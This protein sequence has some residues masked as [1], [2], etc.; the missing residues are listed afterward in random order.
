MPLDSD[1]QEMDLSRGVILTNLT[2]SQRLYDGR[3]Q[4]LASVRMAL[5]ELRHHCAKLLTHDIVKDDLPG[6]VRSNGLDVD[7]PSP[8]RGQSCKPFRRR[9]YVYAVPTSFIEQLCDGIFFRIISP[10]IDVESGLGR[11]FSQRFEEQDILV[12]LSVA[13]N[14]HDPSLK[15]TRPLIP[16]RP[17]M[18][19]LN[20]LSKRRASFKPLK[21]GSIIEREFQLKTLDPTGG[22]RGRRH[23]QEWRGKASHSTAEPGSQRRECG[24][25]RVGGI[26]GP[27]LVA[28]NP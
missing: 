25:L 7:V 22:A 26:V 18:Q 23:R 5:R 27:R 17:G 24:D 9:L 3:A 12:G 8:S 1:L 13:G 21:R 20:R 10:N 28:L 4:R 19:R 11:N 16:L 14:L 15:L 2:E 6:R